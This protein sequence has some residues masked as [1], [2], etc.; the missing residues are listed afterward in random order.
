M[1]Y[2]PIMERSIKVTRSITDAMRPL[3]V[4]FNELKC[5]QKQLPI[6][7][8]SKRTEREYVSAVGDS[9]PSTSSGTGVVQQL[10]A[11]CP[12]ASSS[13]DEGGSDNPI[14]ISS[15]TSEKSIVT[16]QRLR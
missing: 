5:Q 13:S 6:T 3:Y 15:E 10:P 12:S 11:S 9:Q 2:D 16:L 1:V 14:V 8:F 4:L 7:M